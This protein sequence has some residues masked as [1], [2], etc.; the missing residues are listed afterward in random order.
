MKDLS[1]VIVGHVDHGKST[2]IGK[3]LADMDS[4]P[5]GKL[6]QIKELCRRNSKPFEYAFLLDALKDERAQGITIDIARCFFKTKERN[7]IILDAPGHVEFL[8]NMVSGASR[9]EAALLVID[10]AE[11]IQEN[12]KR[13]AYLLSMLGIRQ[14]VVLINKM[15]LINYDIKVFENIK[16][17]YQGFLKDINVVPIAYLPVSAFQGDNI[18]FASVNMPWYQGNT[19]LQTLEQLEAEEALGNMPFR[20]PVQDV[21]KFTEENDDR[22]IIVGTIETGTLKPGDKL[23]FYPSGKTSTVKTIEDLTKKD[24]TEIQAGYAAGVTLAEQ[25]F[26]KRGELAVI[27]GQKKPQVASRL[28]ANL[29]WLG[30]QP[31]VSNKT[32]KMKLGA[33]QVEVRL[34]KIIDTLD[35]SNLHKVTKPQ[36]DCKEV[37]TCIFSLKHSVAFDLNED[38]PITGRFVL[39]DQYEIAGG[40]IITKALADEHTWVREQILEREYKWEKSKISYLERARRYNQKAVCIFISGKKEIDKKTVAKALERELFEEGKYVYYMGMRNLLYGMDA[41]I[42]RRKIGLDRNVEHL[43]RMAETGNI[44]LDAGLILIMSASE[45]SGDEFQ[46]LSEIIGEEKLLKVFIGG[47][48][49]RSENFDVFLEQEEILQQSIGTIKQELKRRGFI[50]DI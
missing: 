49:E 33:A 4:L 5:K 9:A 50:F 45:V 47:E 8:K 46:L 26:I 39:V 32:Y 42:K 23:I 19:V 25:L 13:H 16:R 36:V 17:E 41:D 2:V 31:L 10:A 40:G 6:E 20:M 14:I 44:F 1:L 18:A 35:T 37:A 30:K 27:D 43:R 3:L 29:F 21:Y 11:G 38:M 22:R 28:Q 34:E 12:S 24:I 15:D 7:Y 48:T